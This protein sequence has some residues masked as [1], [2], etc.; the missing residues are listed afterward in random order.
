MML[1]SPQPHCGNPSENIMA[2]TKKSRTART[3]RTAPQVD[4]TARHLWLAGLGL[5]VIARRQGMAAAD[6]LVRRVADARRQAVATAVDTRDTLTEAALSLRSQI[7]TGAGE[8]YGKIEAVAGDAFG[9]IE[10]AV[11]PLAARFG[12][13]KPRR[14]TRR[15][16]KPAAKKAGRRAPAARTARKPVRRSRKG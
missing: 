16:R 1:L 14:A 15:T 7:E 8:A 4:T 11:A 10:A 3:A 6:T 5:A 13:A 2:R 9:K 12:L